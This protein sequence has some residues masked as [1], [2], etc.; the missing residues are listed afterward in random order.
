MSTRIGTIDVHRGRGRPGWMRPVAFSI[1]AFTAAVLAIA[2]IVTVTSEEPVA[3]APSATLPMFEGGQI[4]PG[5]WEAKP[6]QYGASFA[7]PGVSY[8][9]SGYARTFEDTA[10]QRG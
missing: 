10:H 5:R 4:H 3:E 6:A 8:P 2:G 9:A 7:E 1:I